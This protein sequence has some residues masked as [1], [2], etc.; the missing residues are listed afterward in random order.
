MNY[1]YASLTKNIHYEKNLLS[2]LNI[3]KKIL[4]NHIDLVQSQVPVRVLQ[5]KDQDLDQRKA[6]NQ[7][8]ITNI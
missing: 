6:H 7:P 5:E 1:F 3:K 8:Y 4:K 2:T